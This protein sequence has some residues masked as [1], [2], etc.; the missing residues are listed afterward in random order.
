MST[1][2]ISNTANHESLLVELQTEE[3]P[4][5]SLKRLGETFAQALSQHLSDKGLLNTDSVITPLATPRR[6]A[7]HITAVAQ[8]AADQ[9]FTEKLMPVKVGLDENG[10]ATPALLKKLAAKG[11]EHLD[12][13]SLQTIDDGKQTY[14]VASGTA[15]G[16]RLANTI[17]DA[18]AAA[19]QALPIPKVMRY[20]LADGQTSVSFVRPAHGLII[21]HG[22][23]IVVGH[24]LGLTANRLTLGHRFLATQPLSI[25][26]A[27]RYVTQL[28][29]EGHVTASF[30]ERRA[31]IEA[32]L[33]AKAGELDAS[34]GQDPEVDALLDE[35]TALVEAPAV[36]VGTFEAR[37]LDVPPECLI[38]TMRLNQKYFPLFNPET[39]R[40]THQFLIVSNMPIADPSAIITGN[41]R[42]IRPR[43]ADAEFF[44]LTDK[45]QPL[46]NRV[47]ALDTIVYHNK[48]G[49]QRARIERFRQIAAWLA[50]TLGNSGAD[51][52]RAALLAKADLTTLMVGE[53][54]ELQG[55][56]GSYYARADGESN[57]V[58]NAIERQYQIRWH[59]PVTEPDVAGVILFMAERA[60]TLV[61][62]WGI[63][64]APT[65]ERD[66]FALRRAALGLISAF[67]QLSAGGHLPLSMQTNLTLENLLAAARASFGDALKLLPSTV[68]EVAQ[69]VRERYRNQLLGQHTREAI[70]A[71][72]A[73]D[74]PL[75]Q[76]EARIQAAETFMQTPEA[77]SLA[78]A[79]KRLSNLLKKVSDLPAAL[80][81][82]ALQED[83]EKTL[84][85]QIQ[86]IAPVVDQFVALGEYGQA[87]ST[88]ATLKAP[89]DRFFEEI[90]V[91]ADDLEVRR[92]RL[93]LLSNLHH[94]MNQVADIS[95]L[96]A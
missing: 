94:L 71:V 39:G 33:R 91:M 79:N 90:M 2:N 85:N 4:P 42:V 21:L 31:L 72:F 44:Y 7:V 58:I 10:Q 87:L 32:S 29:T 6:L 88:L 60:E 11:L 63:G 26:S 8:A 61:G 19:L 17:D 51:V 86:S 89:V 43:L 62:I 30:G 46:I 50:Q 81:P 69:F 64:L 16:A 78:A 37:F 65:G 24:A 59:A 55:V 83:A 70:E 84:L 54:P 9:S 27:D 67:E 66:P 1:P 3:L 93:A 36:Y 41:E 38:L 47:S 53:F 13:N 12:V 45:R 25:E 5:K 22:D 40:L 76:I 48:L 92:Q 49:T 52:E 68:T 20:Q 34:L 57:A 96:A 77:P 56:M 73:L 74:P 18:L 35:V 14:L 28:A 75:H 80:N 82:A 15:P 23:K 95:R